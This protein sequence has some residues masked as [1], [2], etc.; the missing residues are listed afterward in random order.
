[1]AGADARRIGISGLGG[2]GDPEEGFEVRVLFIS[3][4][5]EVDVFV[6]PAAFSA[7][8]LQFSEFGRVVEVD[9][10][11]GARFLRGGCDGG[12]GCCGHGGICRVCLAEA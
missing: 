1:M 7:L 2:D 10:D 4:G 6:V 9:W 5:D 12:C 3:P 11:E 8:L